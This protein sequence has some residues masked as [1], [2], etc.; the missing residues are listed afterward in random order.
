MCGGSGIVA[1]GA[2]QGRPNLCK[3]LNHFGHEVLPAAAAWTSVRSLCHGGCCHGAAV[4]M[5][6]WG[7]SCASIQVGVVAVTKA[8]G[9]HP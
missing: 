2:A 1:S 4:Y 7:C 8:T 9:A 6:H 3:L 5:C